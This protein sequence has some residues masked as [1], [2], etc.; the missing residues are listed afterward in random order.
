M[1]F[2]ASFISI[3]AKLV[4]YRDTQGKTDCHL[5]RRSF[6]RRI[7]SIHF[8]DPVD[9]QVLERTGRGER[10][11]CEIFILSNSSKYSLLGHSGNCDKNAQGAVVEVK[12]FIQQYNQSELTINYEDWS[13]IQPNYIFL[14]AFAIYGILLFLNSAV[15]ICEI[16]LELKR[17]F[18]KR[19]RILKNQLQSCS[20]DEILSI[21]VESKKMWFW[22]SK[23]YRIEFILLNSS[24]LSIAKYFTL[25]EGEAQRGC[26]ALKEII[27]KDIENGIS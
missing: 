27:R 25:D 14:I 26:R 16:D 6:L 20:F 10:R 3:S 21:R 7:E 15:D 22:R 11:Y 23:G 5:E 19:K 12:N 1:L 13:Y 9:A 4:C 2:L 8:F 17:I 24:P 18:I